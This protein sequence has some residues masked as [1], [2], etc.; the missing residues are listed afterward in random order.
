MGKRT[1]EEVKIILTEKIVQLKAELRR[2]MAAGGA[3][4]QACLICNV[5]ATRHE[6]MV[7]GQQEILYIVEQHTDECTLQ[8]ALHI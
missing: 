5:P 4:R 7:N 8:H 6:L 2:C 3:M 1:P